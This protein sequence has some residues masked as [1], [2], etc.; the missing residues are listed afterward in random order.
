MDPN[1]TV[2]S[3]GQGGSMVSL[4]IVSPTGVE[5]IL[6]NI[7]IKEDGVMGLRSLLQEMPSMCHITSYSLVLLGKDGGKTPLNDYQTLGNYPALEQGGKIAMV[8]SLYDNRS[9]KNHVQRLKDI[10]ACPPPPSLTLS[11]PSPPAGLIAYSKL[12]ELRQAMDKKKEAAED[13]VE[14]DNANVV[15]VD[16]QQ[17]VKDAET[18]LVATTKL[19][20][21]FIRGEMETSKATAVASSIPVPFSVASLPNLYVPSS[22]TLS[23]LPNLNTSK[24]SKKQKPMP[25]CVK[26]IEYSVYNPPRASRILFGDLSYLRVMFVDNKNAVHLTCTAHGYFVNQST[27]I[28]FNPEPLERKL[29]HSWILHSTSY[30]QLLTIFLQ[31]SAICIIHCWIH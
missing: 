12:I 3:P 16:L 5:A 25:V 30:S 26:S 14:E 17:K 4:T 22:T 8:T 10:I 24:I 1:N 18:E 15:S 20:A 31:L 6:H 23:S 13:K 7:N 11:P 9:S 27:D 21:P 29:Q 2:T 19:C 28:A